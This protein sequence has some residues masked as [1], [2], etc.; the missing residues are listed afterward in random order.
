MNNNTVASFSVKRQE[1]QFLYYL[2]LK[3]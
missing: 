2:L 3:L 1:I